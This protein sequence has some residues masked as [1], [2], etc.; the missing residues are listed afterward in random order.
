MNIGLRWTW[1]LD[2][3]QCVFLK[4]STPWP[5]F[6]GICVFQHT[7]P[8]CL[9]YP[10]QCVRR[11]AHR[12]EFGVRGWAVTEN[13]NLL[14]GHFPWRCV[15]YVSILQGGV[16]LGLCYSVCFEIMVH[17][18]NPRTIFPYRNNLNYPL[19]ALMRAKTF[20]CVWSTKYPSEIP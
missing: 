12:A 17:S 10:V 16:A 18:G 4:S 6:R 15:I 20:I 1:I 3:Q 14:F 5:H 19:S 13:L 8:F 11:K 9:V 2:R 7:S